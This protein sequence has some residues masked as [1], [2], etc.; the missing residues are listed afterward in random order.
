[1]TARPPALALRLLTWRLSPEW[2]DFV[3]GDLEEEFGDRARLSVPAAR[4]WFWRQTLRCVAR[5]PRHHQTLPIRTGDPF[6][7]TLLSDVR[8]ALRVF[9]RAPSYAVAVVGVLALAIGANT[10]I[11][12]IVNA[13]LLRPLSFSEPDRLVRL[14]HI[15]PQ[16]T[17]PGLPTFSLSP[18]NFL[19]WQRDST[20]FTGAAA[21]NFRQLT[22][23]GS[24]NAEALRAAVV[25]P[26]FFTIVG[27][28]PALGR[29]FLADEH[30]PNARVI[31]ISDG[32]W[33][34]HLG[35][36]T[37]A[38]GRTLTFDGQN[39]TV[40]GVMPRQF[41]VKAWGATSV[42]LWTPLA[43]SDKQ[44][45]VRE[46]H[47][48]NAIARL[49]PGVTLE[50]A[51]SELQV[52]SK[53]LEQTYPADNAG[54]GGTAIPLQELIV[55]DVRTSLLMLLVAVG[56][57][58]LIACAN[59]GNLILARAINRRKELAI[60]AAL[61]AGRRRVF[62][63]LL[64]ESVVLALVGGVA[65]LLL[66]R[67]ALVAGA[68]LLA[69]QVPRAEE[70]SI[71]VRVLLF[72]VAASIVTGLLA[73]LVPALRAGRS[74]LNDTLKEGGR[75]DV[76]GAGGLMRRGLIVAEVALSLMLLMGAGVMLRSLHAL[77]SVD[78]GFNPRNVLRMD[79]NLPDAKYTEPAQRRVFFDSLMDRLRA[80]PGAQ[81]AGWADTLPATGGGSVQPMVAEGKAEL[82]PREQPTVSVRF[83]SPA[84]MK[85]MEIPML[86]GRD[87]ASG[88]VDA[89]LV[90]AS[91][92]R[93]LWGEADPVGRRATLPLMSRTKAV[94]V[95]GVVG[96]VRETLA[97]KAPPTVYYHMRDL[98]FGDAA[99]A[100]RTTGDPSTLAHAA[101][102]AVH[103]LDPQ[104]PVQEVHSMEEVIEGTLVAERFRALLLQVF[105]V[106]AL[107]LASV[108]IYSVLSYLVRGR[109][110]E[111]GIRT[112]LGARTS[113]VLGMVLLEGLKPAALGIVL[114][115]AGALIAAGLLEKLVFGVKASDP[116]TLAVVATSLLLVSVLASL[117]P[118]WRAV[119]LDPLTVLRDG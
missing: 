19:D 54:W 104:L 63:H 77:R 34:S 30:A 44:A 12:S 42:P 10:A 80:L 6:V 24:G 13:V 69:D 101:V 95:I 26:G 57:V 119:K 45:A 110:R 28:P 107:T 11:F 88:D 2:V 72:V 71:D 94:E 18:A 55:G 9:V 14:F 96:D 89:L 48:Y 78:A 75:S 117:L 74:D 73:G 50:Q 109:R 61:G 8:H 60:R 51:K 97:E 35:S 90:S 32:F 37:D 22:L 62:Q 99:I 23:T 31:V 93:L 47:N 84:Y 17:F 38:V 68:S 33:K 36:A 87:F 25:G 111:I 86:R 41:S 103:A 40:V 1:M 29:T 83:A 108:G 114:G 91:A 76:A 105:A 70:A 66:A 106:A 113:D 46:N 27:T 52:I 20:S 4:R 16:A 49:K 39:Y 85:T 82:N 58:L 112:A 98:P 5:P 7:L 102:A 65:G 53:R 43:W 15:P 115:A 100:I 118:A 56:L 81:S 79:V 59:V 64:V 116:L 92:A 3:V 21:Y 67:T